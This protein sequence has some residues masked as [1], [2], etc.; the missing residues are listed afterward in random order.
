MLEKEGTQ[1]RWK[2]IRNVAQ[3]K[4]QGSELETRTAREFLSR[5]LCKN[6]KEEKVFQIKKGFWE[7]RERWKSIEKLK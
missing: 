4:R 7:E 2:G 6:I 5:L 1:H 3:V